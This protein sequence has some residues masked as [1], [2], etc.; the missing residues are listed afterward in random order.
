MEEYHEKINRLQEEIQRKDK[1]LER[2]LTETFSGDD[3]RLLAQGIGTGL[4]GSSRGE[5]IHNKCDTHNA[6]I[7]DIKEELNQ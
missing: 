7:Q 2:V 1:L 5:E 4:A 6:L 3:V